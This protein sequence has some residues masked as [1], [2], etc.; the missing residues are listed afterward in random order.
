MKARRKPAGKKSTN[1]FTVVESSDDGSDN[2]RAKISE[3]FS[4]FEKAKHNGDKKKVV[5]LHLTIQRRQSLTLFVLVPE[6]FTSARQ[7]TRA[8]QKVQQEEKKK[9]RVRCDHMNHIRSNLS[10]LFCRFVCQTALSKC[11]QKIQSL[12]L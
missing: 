12:V 6:P 7:R 8:V 10:S 2:E 9:R 1:L 5:G 4:K 11:P 3:S